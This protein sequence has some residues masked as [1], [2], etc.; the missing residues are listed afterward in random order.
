MC[1]SH[2]KWNIKIRVVPVIIG[3]LGIVE[4]KKIAKLKNLRKGQICKDTRVK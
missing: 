2:I 3:A 4:E 1:Q